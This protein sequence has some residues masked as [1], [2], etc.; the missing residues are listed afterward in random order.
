MTLELRSAEK[1]A[2][3]W[4]TRAERSEGGSQVLRSC[5]GQGQARRAVQLE[6][7]GAGAP[8]DTGGLRLLLQV[9]W[10]QL[11]ES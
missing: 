2:T 7:L 6:G 1:R 4:E 3:S 8:E 10:K 11:K 9:L 5:G